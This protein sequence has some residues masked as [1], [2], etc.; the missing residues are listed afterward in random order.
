MSFKLIVL[1]F[2]SLTLLVSFLYSSPSAAVLNWPFK[3]RRA[4]NS[5]DCQT[6]VAGPLLNWNPEFEKRL[7]YKLTEEQ[8]QA[9]QNVNDE[10][11][12]ELWVKDFLANGWKLELL[13]PGVSQYLFRAYR[14]KRITIHEFTTGMLFH[15]AKVETN[16]D[17]YR[18]F[19]TVDE[20]NIDFILDQ[21]IVPLKAEHRLEFKKR[22]LAL[23]KRERVLFKALDLPAG[24]FL[25]AIGIVGSLIPPTMEKVESEL[26]SS[27]TYLMIP[28]IG[29]RYTVSRNNVNS[30]RFTLL[31]SSIRQILSDV[32]H[33]ENSVQYVSVIGNENSFDMANLFAQKGRSVAIHFPGV[34]VHF[35]HR[36]NPQDYPLTI[37]IHDYYH[38][39]KVSRT[40]VHLRTVVVPYLLNFIQKLK[41]QAWSKLP[42]VY[43]TFS[44]TTLYTAHITHQLSFMGTQS[45]AEE[46]TDNEFAPWKLDNYLNRLAIWSPPRNVDKESYQS[47]NYLV[48][49]SILEDMILNSAKWQ[50]MGFGPKWL[51][52]FI[53]NNA[54]GQ[55]HFLYKLV[56]SGEFAK[57]R[58]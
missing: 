41:G 16:S 20:S 32:M 50:E 38:N 33:G 11:Q 25:T 56:Q 31:S 35:P 43:T 37:L 5:T 10:K 39:E 53:Q 18:S 34:K 12:Y 46:L 1:H 19:L 23:G 4:T 30:Y 51:E 14:E 55:V 22:V 9:M 26:Q 40:P 45:S 17:S 15:S 42:V 13:V 2:L 21:E 27:G 3:S 48:L 36:V 7:T 44:G 24:H 58:N 49:G 54:H 52:S 57:Y 6:R 47:D 29:T 28:P 8:I